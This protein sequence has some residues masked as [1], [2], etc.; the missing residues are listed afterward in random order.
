MLTLLARESAMVRQ[1][2]RICAGLHQMTLY[3]CLGPVGFLLTSQLCIVILRYGFGIGYLQ[4]QDFSNYVFASLVTLSLPVALALDRHVRVDV[5]REHQTARQRHR[6]D[7][8]GVVLLLIPVFSLSIY[9][10]Y[11]DI[12]YAWQIREGSRE[13]GGLG[14][15]FLVKTLFPVSC[16][17]I[18]LQGIALLLQRPT[19]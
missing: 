6:L 4:L 2:V 19:P 16:V 1:F 7:V 13:T 17:L 15:V 12:L 8:A 5:L 14:G 3:L 9:L 18:I 10:V 11:P